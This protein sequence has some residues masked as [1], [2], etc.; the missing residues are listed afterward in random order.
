MGCR[1]RAGVCCERDGVVRRGEGVVVQQMPRCAGQR[2]RRAHCER[3]PA[4]QRHLA[5][6]L[7]LVLEP[8]GDVLCFPKISKRAN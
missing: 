8:D 1:V 5:L 2:L 7:A 3:L 6:I 4:L